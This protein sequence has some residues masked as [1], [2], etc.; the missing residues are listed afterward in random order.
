METKEEIMKEWNKYFIPDTN[1]LINNLGI[2]NEEELFNRE[3]EITFE[4]LLQLYKNPIKMNFDARHL[5]EIHKYLFCDIYPFAGEYR[6]VYM[7]KN[8]SYFAPVSQI[9]F[10]VNY[11]L[12]QMSNEVNHISTLY[13]FACFLAGSYIELLQIHPFREGNGR[14]IREFIREYA[15]D[16][17]KNLPFGE[18]SF[19]WANIDSEAIN[20]IIDKSVAFKSII[21]LEF[22]KALE[23]VSTD[24]IVK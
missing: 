17:S 14:T 1:V 18:V 9:D 13:D 15:N 11:V 8:N 7:Q 21:E 5:K 10:R 12:D 6:K 23:I 19:S 22:L 4:K 20:D 3:L 2:T 16:K 24:R